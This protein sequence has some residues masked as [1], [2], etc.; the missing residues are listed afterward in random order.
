MYI[1]CTCSLN[2]LSVILWL[3]F[4]DKYSERSDGMLEILNLDRV[5]QI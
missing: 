2:V 3:E 5:M 1:L 4:R